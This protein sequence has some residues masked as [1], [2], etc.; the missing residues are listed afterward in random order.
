VR[1]NGK[2]MKWMRRKQERRGELGKEKPTHGSKEKFLAFNEDVSIPTRGFSKHQRESVSSKMEGVSLKG[3][4][5]G[6]VGRV[7]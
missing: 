7:C 1:G 6:R 4:T 5:W 2:K 3:E